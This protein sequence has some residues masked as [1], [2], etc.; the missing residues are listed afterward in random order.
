MARRRAG[1]AV[2][3]WYHDSFARASAKLSLRYLS[4]FARDLGGRVAV[5]PAPSHDIF[6]LS[7]VPPPEPFWRHSWTGSAKGGKRL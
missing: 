5:T 6:L 1:N 3:I 4:A 7:S 2:E